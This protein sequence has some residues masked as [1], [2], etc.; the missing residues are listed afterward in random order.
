MEIDKLILNGK[1]ICSKN[2]FYETLS[3]LLKYFFC[4]NGINIMDIIKNVTQSELEFQTFM[5]YKNY[6]IDL[7]YL[8]KQYIEDIRY[9]D[10]VYCLIAMVKCNY[11]QNHNV[12][13]PYVLSLETNKSEI[14]EK[15]NYVKTVYSN[16]RENIEKINNINKVISLFEESKEYD[17]KA[18][19]CRNNAVKLLHI[20]KE[21][22]DKTSS[23]IPELK[24]LKL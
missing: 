16:K 19:E 10:I 2:P 3:L 22:Y 18:N 15:Y 5:I 12:I 13:S 4:D 20:I 9:D 1:H 24:L 23:V 8:H 21:T 6:A 14:I 17:R 11:D 7:Y